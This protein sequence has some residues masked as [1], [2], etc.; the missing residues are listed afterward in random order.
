MTESVFSSSW[1]RVA[2]LKPRV[3]GHARIHR[4]DYRGQI[5]F[6]LQDP[7]S[8]RSHR[9][10]AA[11]HTLIGLMDG[12]RSVQAIWDAASGQLGDDAPT[13]DEVIRL[14]GQLH[15]ADVLNCDVPPDS[16][17]LFKRY[18]RQERQ[19]WK[20]RLWSPLAIRI[21]L[22]DPERFLQRL[23]PLVR[24]LFGWFGLILW[25]VVVIAG[26][27]LAGLHWTDIT[28]D[29]VDRVLA[30]ENLL[31]L[32]LIY[33]IV[34]ALHELGHGFAIKRWGGEVHEMGIMF[35]V[36][37]PVPYVDASSASAFREKGKRMLVGAAGMIVE[38]FLAAA[39]L[40]VWVNAEP[41]IA[42]TIAYNVML[43][44]GVSM[45]L[46]NGNPL[47][48]FDGYYVL[49]DA[50]EIPNLASR[51]TKYLGYLVKRYLLGARDLKSPA[52]APGERA[53]FLCYGIAAFAYRLF[54]MTVIILFV[55]EK[56]FFVGVL[57]AI[58]AITTQ[59][60]VPVGKAVCAL[61]TDVNI[62]PRRARALTVV[63]TLLAALTAALFFAPAPLWTRAQGVVWVPEQGRVRAGTDGFVRRLLVAENA[64]VAV[65][66]PLV[67]MEDLFL[68]ARVRVLVALLRELNARFT[69]ERIRD[70][71]QAQMTRQEIASV[72]ADL[73][74]ARERV[75]ELTVRSPADGVLVVPQAQDLPGRY[76]RQGQL[77]AYV[78]D[79][80]K[81]TV[82]V[83]ISQEDVGLF[84]Q[85][86][87]RV[88]AMMADWQ[89]QPLPALVERLVP[90]ASTRL[91]S[92]ALGTS[93]GGS[94][95]V[96][97]RDPEGLQ[98]LERVFEFDV[99]LLEIPAAGHIGRRVHLRFDYGT[100]PLAY[101]WYRSLRQLFLRR[102][103][104]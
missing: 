76:L 15:A 94:I 69:A 63:G 41:G 77:I 1:Y 34:K 6:V 2:A 84:R 35:L 86:F 103:D 53:W 8:G 85:R 74:R 65:G 45:L 26:L 42:R 58:W 5:W 97:P 7:S 37:M 64:R 80:D 47:L 29:V 56:F 30:P 24:P 32:W 96:D 48:R 101:Q 9:F 12:D 79:P 61:F 73:A 4:H 31:L 62:R 46:F 23:L 100:E 83:A 3:R 93:G 89:S 87:R 55:A 71:V 81:T 68:Q 28:E 19:K 14:L 67:E 54:I 22:L 60:V 104:A 57:L 10:S 72:S 99:A 70:R 13:Q 33:P 11:A 50:V 90:A 98:T 75:A 95:P 17:E 49:A 21:P 27:V 66:D 44:G 88:D 102:F 51:A 18:Q 59:V 25:L 91:A 82:R 20:R 52:S 36:F 78:A 38:L 43:I 92:A 39:A 40:L 16:L